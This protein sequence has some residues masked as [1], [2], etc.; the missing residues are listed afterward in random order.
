MKKRINAR[1][2]PNYGYGGY[3]ITDEWQCSGDYYTMISKGFKDACHN[4]YA[5]FRKQH[6][7]KKYKCTVFIC[8]S[9]SN[10]KEQKIANDEF[11]TLKECRSFFIETIYAYQSSDRFQREIVDTYLSVKA[12]P[13]FTMEDGNIQIIGTTFF[14]VNHEYNDWSNNRTETYSYYNNDFPKFGGTRNYYC[15]CRDYRGE[16]RITHLYSFG[17]YSYSW[18]KP[19]E[20]K[21]V[22]ERL[23]PI[24]KDDHRFKAMYETLALFEEGRKL[25]T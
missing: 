17:G 3:D 12:S 13:V 16:F 22:F 8:L 2:L 10:S 5:D 14:G 1:D 20:S 18:L 21:E 4:Y 25:V 9:A 23:G 11:D 6:L 7:G 19:E 24:I 15:L